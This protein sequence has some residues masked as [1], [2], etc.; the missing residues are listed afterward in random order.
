MTLEDEYKLYVESYFGILIV[1]EYNLKEYALNEIETI[2]KNF[3]KNYEEIDYNKIKEYVKEKES[4]K[5]KLQSALIVL[6]SINYD[7]DLILLIKD[8]NNFAF[9]AAFNV[10]SSSKSNVTVT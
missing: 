10:T 7:M 9:T 5:T 3:K 4:K 8:K 6:N 1:N 2:I